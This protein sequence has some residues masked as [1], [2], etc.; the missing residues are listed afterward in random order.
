[1][2]ETGELTEFWGFA[3]ADI[4]AAGMIV[5]LCAVCLWLARRWGRHL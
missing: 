5:V 1:M 4:L 2:T 3:G